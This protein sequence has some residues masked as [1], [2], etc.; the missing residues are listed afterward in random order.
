MFDESGGIDV[1]ALDRAIGERLE[2]DGRALVFIN[3]PCHNP[4]GY[5]MR[6]EEWKKV[7]ACIRAHAKKG[8]VT[9]LVD[10][11]YF[12]YAA[13]DPTAFLPELVP[14]AGEAGL[15]CAWSASKTFTHYGLRVGALVAC[16]PDPDLR[17]QTHA[18]LCY[19]S[20][21]TWSNC[22]RGGMKAIAKLLTDPEMAKAV[23]SERDAFRT[24]LND[25]VA[26]FNEHAKKRG[27]VY[28]RYE[29]GFFVTVFGQ[30]DAKEKA[31]KMRELGVFAVP[32]SGALRVALCS[33]AARDIPRL[34]DALAG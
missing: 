25:R 28:P 23:N 5:S 12:A 32:A 3:D 4:T 19:S 33:V 29:G 31:A 24:L 15:L 1:V 2:A 7:V 21:G 16:V 17:K 10:V 11:A 26:V 8:P 18:A 20:R 14:L 30:G 27:L 22:S 9:L 6:R 34:V 13:G